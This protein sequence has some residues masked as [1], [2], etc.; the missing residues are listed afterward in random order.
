ME[1]RLKMNKFSNSYRGDIDL[2]RAFAVI[3]VLIFHFFP[4]SL[5]G[6]FLGVDVFFVIS[7]YLV[8]RNIL[9]ET[10]RGSFSFPSFYLKR[11]K[12]LYPVLLLVLSFTLVAGY[13]F[14]LSFEFKEVAKHILGSNFF[15]NNI[16]LY[17][18][19]G[20]FDK[21]SDSKPLL[22]LWSLAVEE[23]FY[24]FWPFVLTFSYKYLKNRLEN[25]LI[26]LIF[27]SFLFSFYTSYENPSFSFYMLPSRF[28]QIAIGGLLA[29]IGLRGLEEKVR[30]KWFDASVVGLGLIILGILIYP[31]NSNPMIYSIIVVIGS[32]LFL[33]SSE[34]TNLKKLINTKF[35]RYIGLISYPLYLWHWPIIVFYRTFKN[36]PISNLESLILI[37]VT[38][39]L[40]VLS[41]EFVERGFKNSKQI[42]KTSI[43]LLF[44]NIALGLIGGFIIFQDGLT[45]RYPAL[46]SEY[47]SLKRFD[48]SIGN[49]GSNCRDAF[50]D[51]EMCS[52]SQLDKEP[53]AVLIGDSHANHYFVG[54]SEYLGKKN[55][56]LL[57]LGRSGTAPL[58]HVESLRNPSSNLN[59]AIDFILKRKS[60]KTVYLAAFWSN[61]SEEKGTRVNNGFYKNRIR[62]MKGGDGSQKEIFLEGLKRTLDSFINAGKDVVFIHDIPALP[63]KLSHC[64]ERPLNRNK[65]NC[66]VDAATVEEAFKEYRMILVDLSNKYGDK[67][68][69]IDPIPAMCSDGNCIIKNKSEMLYS[70]EH[71]L[72]IAGSKYVFQTL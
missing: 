57:L 51:I 19:S 37:V 8:T 65:K 48:L 42:S 6:G 66:I 12:R 41:Y 70:D 29:I 39:G 1:K 21:S 52:I 59:D 17:S 45:N 15:L 61:Y 9:S 31:K 72:S 2:L 26:A 36:E 68:R 60:I 53:D 44:G 46:E 34:T 7:G 13:F 16:I 35:I 47:L 49:A 64:L 63:F 30:Y 56:N 58:I 69:I 27:I 4:S 3:S 67:I 43:R 28:W 24:I 71:H 40:S 50:L 22:H 18:E 11:V 32:L 10:N 62:D 33:A 5:R 25:V 20:Y 55:E 14:L 23:Q 38:V 54:L